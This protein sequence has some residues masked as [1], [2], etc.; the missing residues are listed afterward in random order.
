MKPDQQRVSDIVMQTVIKLCASG[1]QGSTTRIQGVIGV[2]V[3]DNDVFVIH[4]ND[5]VDNVS[6]GG[7]APP[8]CHNVQDVSP[9]PVSSAAVSAGCASA[10][11]RARHRLVFEAPDV[12]S[13]RQNE[14]VEL[15]TRGGLKQS[16]IEASYSRMEDVRQLKQANKADFTDDLMQSTSMNHDQPTAAKSSVVVVDSDDEDVKLVT[17][18]DMSLSLL[19]SK[20]AVCE[21]SMMSG[22]EKENFADA[23]SS[24]DPLCAA[25][26]VSNLCIADVV[27]SVSSWSMQHDASLPQPTETSPTVLKNDLNS[28]RDDNDVTVMEEEEFETTQLCAKATPPRRFRVTF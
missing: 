13:R 28:Y 4:I 12:S 27:G 15:E 24:T 23:S 26:A 10:R 1:L 16:C 9:I 21:K 6:A 19:S 11:K 20:H 18:Q 17:D 2:T 7:V 22:A 3:D 5:K 8:H 14:L 25:D